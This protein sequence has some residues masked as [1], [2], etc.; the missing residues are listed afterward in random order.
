MPNIIKPNK[1]QIAD[2]LIDE[3]ISDMTRYLMDD[4]GFSM[5]QALDI[6]YTSHLM[7]LLQN[8]ESELYIQSSAYN[9]ES[10]QKEKGL[11][12]VTQ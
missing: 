8:H 9:Y 3:I 7:T 5:N 1:E 11:A 10:L 2:Y 12:I 6:V 4:Y